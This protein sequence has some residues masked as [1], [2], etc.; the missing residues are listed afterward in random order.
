M[1]CDRLTSPEQ[2]A[3]GR[4]AAEPKLDGQRAQLHVQGGRTVACY[5][6]RGLD[7]LVH[8]GM[9]WLRGLTWPVET[10][11][12]DGEATAGDGHESIHAV[13]E[14]RKR[15]DDGAMAIV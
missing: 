1:L 6:R 12:F 3:S 15:P 11:V 10:A 13:F 5:S 7:L 14:A 4:F 2:L 9:A 8:P